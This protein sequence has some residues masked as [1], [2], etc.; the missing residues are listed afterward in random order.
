MTVNFLHERSDQAGAGRDEKNM[1]QYAYHV[2]DRPW[3]VCNSLAV[4]D[5]WQH[6]Y[7]SPTG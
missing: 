5:K 2:Q 6:L 3:R 4:V 1:V 7:I